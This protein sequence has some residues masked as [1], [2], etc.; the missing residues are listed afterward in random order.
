MNINLNQGENRQDAAD[1]Q[2]YKDKANESLKGGFKFISVLVV[3]ILIIFL[4]ANSLYVVREDEIATIREFGEIKRIV[5]DP[6]NTEAEIF[7]EQDSRFTD[8]IVDTTK[9]LKFKIPFITDVEKNTSKTLTYISNSAQIN[10]RD[11]IKYEINMYAQ[12]N[13][14]HPGIF[15][16]SLGSITRANSKIDEVA[17]AVVIEQINSLLSTEFLADKDALESVLEEARKAL[18]VNLASQGIKL[19]DID[20]YRT[21]LPPSN[22]ES[23]Y[24]KMVAEREAIA[25][26]I[27]SEGMEIYQN[28]VADTDRE[29]AQIKSAAIEESETIK[30]EADAT[31]LE[32]YASG[33]NRDPEFYQFW[34]T[35][36]SYEETVDENTVIYLDKNNSYLDIFSNGQ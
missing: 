16:T 13:I 20:I 25:Q 34:R 31:A 12:W 17:Y 3:V 27:R 10:T 14:V 28:T 11:K 35:L 32:V 21:I 6:M 29:V 9:G 2:A 26:Q 1:F 22:I 36:K 30:G 4:L 19:V 23:T 5:V 18:N 24:K 8:V 15:R 7:N 33:F